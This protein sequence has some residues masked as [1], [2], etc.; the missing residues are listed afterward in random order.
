MVSIET[1]QTFLR[2]N[3]WADDEVFRA[4]EVFSDEQL[5]RAFEMGRGSLR[6]AV[7]PRTASIMS[8]TRRASS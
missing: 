8:P 1:I 6:T 5:D 3:D 2:Y 4:S 7:S